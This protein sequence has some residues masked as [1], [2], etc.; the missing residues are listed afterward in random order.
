VSSSSR[1]CGEDFQFRDDRGKKVP[2]R[3]EPKP[4]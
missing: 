2:R 3:E 4:V 1:T